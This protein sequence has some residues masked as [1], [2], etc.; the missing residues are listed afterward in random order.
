MFLFENFKYDPE[1][2]VKYYEDFY[3]ASEYFANYLNKDYKDN[4]KFAVRR[5][6]D[7]N[8]NDNI[9]EISFIDTYKIFS[10]GY[11]DVFPLE[12]H[13]YAIKKLVDLPKELIRRNH[14]E[15]KESIEFFERTCNAISG[16]T[17]ENYKERDDFEL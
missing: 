11:V 14:I 10:D 17:Q 9:Y 6:W 8:H 3:N 15:E 2:A 5:C 1:W 12:A 4:G 16:K 7:K 13:R